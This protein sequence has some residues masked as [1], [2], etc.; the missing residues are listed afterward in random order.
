MQNASIWCNLSHLHCKAVAREN[1]VLVI[2]QARASH[3]RHQLRAIV[4]R[5]VDRLRTAQVEVF[6]DVRAWY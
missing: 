1:R 3:K 6:F 5:F 4:E 2:R